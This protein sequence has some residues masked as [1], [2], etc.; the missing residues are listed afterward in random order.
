MCG[1]NRCIYY[2]CDY[3]CWRLDRLGDQVIHLHREECDCLNE[4]NAELCSPRCAQQY[5][6]EI[7]DCTCGSP[8][9]T[10]TTTGVSTK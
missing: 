9:T 6:T 3:C 2:G 1:K 5:T 7:L 8:N 10:T 4:T